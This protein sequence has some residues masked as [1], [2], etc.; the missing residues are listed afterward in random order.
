METP[1]S[2]LGLTEMHP[3]L[4]WPEIAAATVTIFEDGR[5]EAPFQITIEMIDVPG[6]GNEK[7]A[8]L[9]DRGGFPPSALPACAGP[10]KRLVA[11]SWPPLL[12]RVWPFIMEVVMKS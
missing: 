12:S 3:E 9:I 8:L 1:T 11:S 10:T 6:F 7:L 5:L 2:L 4:E